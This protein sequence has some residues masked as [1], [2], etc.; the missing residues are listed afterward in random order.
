VFPIWCRKSKDSRGRFGS[1]GGKSLFMP[2]H[3]HFTA[4]CSFRWL[5]TYQAGILTPRK[6]MCNL[7]EVN[8]SATV[9][10]ITLA[11][12]ATNISAMGALKVQPPAWD[13][14]RSSQRLGKS[15]IPW[16]Y[17]SR[18][19][20]SIHNRNCRACDRESKD[21]SCQRSD[22]SSMRSMGSACRF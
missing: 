18:E 15:H 2:G 8:N 1:V 13:R 11:C 21:P 17:R 10:A 12:W 6:F 5:Q 16:D 3:V 20:P 14:S 7:W 19:C 22:P 9:R 4:H